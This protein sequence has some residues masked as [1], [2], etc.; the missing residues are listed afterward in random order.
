[1]A[2]DEPTTDESTRRE[3]L[4]YGGAV[5]GGATLAGCSGINPT[6]T[7]SDGGGEGSYSV[8]ME[9]VGTVEFE[10]V[11]ETVTTFT[12]DYIEM[13][14]A[15]G[16]GDAAQSVW[17]QNRYKT[18]HY[19]ELDGVSIDTDQL[20]SMWSDGIS[21]ELLY[22]LDG[23][24]H[25]M[26]PHGLTDWMDDWSDGDVDEIRENVAPFLGNLIF[27]R[28]DDWHDYRYYT[29]YE[30]FEK[31]S[32]IF[33]ETDR[34]EAVRS[35]HDDVVTEIESRIPSATERPNALLLFAGEEPTE[36]APYRISGKGANKEHFR[37]LGIDDAFAGTGT[38]GYTDGQS[39]DYETLLDVDPDALLLRYHGNK[40]D[41]EFENTIV[42]FLRNHDVA[43]RLTAVE[44][45]MVFQGS[46]IYCGPL[47]NLFELDRLAS[48]FYPD[49]FGG[50]ELFDRDEL[51]GII[52]EGASE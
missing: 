5:L 27:R 13:M 52:T 24:L 29:L 35:L 2:T 38:E 42:D 8:T 15:L 45:D 1:M 12:P 33:Q 26:D 48:A 47:H 22:E 50:E 44:N 28:T 18:M 20:T 31:V 11:P 16:H 19:D 49:E 37:T 39:V 9:P 10:E 4:A 40:T 14:V 23:D 51:A 41:A 34:F 43:S 17:Y 36:F 7:E 6:S 3:Y 21:Q 25:L 32:E 30:A 46:P